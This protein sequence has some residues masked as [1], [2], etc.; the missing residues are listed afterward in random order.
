M[1]LNSCIASVADQEGVDVEHIIQDAGSSDLDLPWIAAHPHVRLIPERDS[2]MYDAINRGM[3]KA[4]SE[5]LAHL[6]ADEQYLPGALEAVMKCFRLDPDLDMVFADSVIIDT[7]GNFICCR[8]SL[9]PQR[10]TRFVD[11]PTITSSIFFRRRILKK[12]QLYF[13]TDWKVLGDALWIRDCVMVPGLKMK[14]LRRYT[15]AFAETGDNL[16]LS[17]RAW[18]ESERM[19]KANPI[20]TSRLKVP[21]KLY[22]RFRRLLSGGYDQ[23]PFAYQI[24][25]PGHVA[26]RTVFDVENPTCVWW[27]RAPRNAGPLY[28]RAKH[29]LLKLLRKS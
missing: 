24:Y 20:W 23:A 3:K 9:I 22:A 27:T 16:D 13:D 21:L 18:E 25:L 29:G 28:R 6:N 10:L 8:K 7:S 14:V 19:R 26:E 4:R 2:G 15:T 1:W 11:N 5:I 17:P 12:H